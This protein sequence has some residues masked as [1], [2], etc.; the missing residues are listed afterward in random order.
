MGMQRTF[1]LDTPKT[2]SPR[3]SE[4]RPEQRCPANEG[5]VLRVCELFEVGT[6]SLLSFSVRIISP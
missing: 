5:F 4:F 2:D 6:L 1:I 3:M